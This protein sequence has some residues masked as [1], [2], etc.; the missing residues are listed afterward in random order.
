MLVAQHLSPLER[1]L[2]LPAAVIEGEAKRAEPYFVSLAIS[3]PT[4]LT[5]PAVMGEQFRLRGPVLD[6]ETHIWSMATTL[7]ISR[8]TLYAAN[9]ATTEP[10]TTPA[11]SASHNASDSRRMWR[12]LTPF[13]IPPFCDWWAEVTFGPGDGFVTT[14]ETVDLTQYLVL[15]GQQLKGTAL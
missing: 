14:Q 11:Y 5:Q 12:W 13:V 8:V 4:L 9:G 2:R 15:Q 10:L 3:H 1:L 6:S 7:K